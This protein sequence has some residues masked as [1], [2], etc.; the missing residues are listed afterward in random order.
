MWA[1]VNVAQAINARAGYYLRWSFDSVGSNP[2]FS[3]LFFGRFFFLFSLLSF[4]SQE[5]SVCRFKPPNNASQIRWFNA[6]FEYFLLLTTRLSGR[7]FL[8]DWDDLLQIVAL[9]RHQALFE[10]IIVFTIASLN[11]WFALCIW[12]KR[13]QNIEACDDE[14]NE[15]EREEIISYIFANNHNMLLWRRWLTRTCVRTRHQMFSERRFESW[16]N[17]L[18]FALFLLFY[19]LS[20]C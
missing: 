10:T 9:V 7:V 3:F 15:A 20:F 17:P 2:T 5:K 18:F 19:L 8:I 6:G 14:R 1:C 16:I 4:C 12:G 11:G 13:G